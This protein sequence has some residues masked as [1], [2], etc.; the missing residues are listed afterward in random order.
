MPRFSPHLLPPIL[1]SLHSSIQWISLTI[2]VSLSVCFS[3]YS[4]HRF[5]IY[6]ILVGIVDFSHEVP[7]VLAEVHLISPR[8]CVG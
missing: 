3:R 5:L 4:R 6:L 1:P 8:L 2:L 7:S